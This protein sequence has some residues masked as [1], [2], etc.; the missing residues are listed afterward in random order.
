M[1]WDLK[2]IHDRCVEEGECWLW[3]QGVNSRGYPQMSFNGRRG[4]M[5]RRVAME[6]AGRACPQGMLVEAR[7]K[8]KLCVNP[9]HLQWATFAMMPKRGKENGSYKRRDSYL[10]HVAANVSTG[11]T[12]LTWGLVRD[13]RADFAHGMTIAQVQEKYGLKQTC[14]YN[15]RNHKT[16]R[17]GAFV[18]LFAR[19]RVLEAA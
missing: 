3:G 10:R 11:A 7:C 19:V 1:K 9:A 8:N 16:W 17:E 13:I 6:L 4:L 2:A 12:R 18:E 5:V 15:L 14:A